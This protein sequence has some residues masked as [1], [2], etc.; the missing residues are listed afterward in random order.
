M[1]PA[2]EPLLSQESS[3]EDKGK[4]K[5]SN[6]DPQPVADVPS[7]APTASDASVETPPPFKVFKPPTGPSTAL[8]EHAIP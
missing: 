4:G 2:S 1:D 6:H 7:T 5:E 3:Y 8:R